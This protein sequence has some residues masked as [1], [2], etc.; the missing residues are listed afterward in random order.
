MMNDRIWIGKIIMERKK[1]LKFVG[2][3]KVTEERAGSGFVIQW[4][5]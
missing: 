3:L 2:I 1:N 5:G 4:F